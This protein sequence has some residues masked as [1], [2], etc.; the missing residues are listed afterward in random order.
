MLNNENKYH[1][2]KYARIYQIVLIKFYEIYKT[3]QIKFY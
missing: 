1:N 3:I 2:K